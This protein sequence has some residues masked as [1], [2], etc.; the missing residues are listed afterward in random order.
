MYA[1]LLLFQAYRYRISE[2][3]SN[4]NLYFLDFK[5]IVLNPRHIFFL[6]LTRFDILSNPFYNK[7]AN[8]EKR[9]LRISHVNPI[10]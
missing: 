10:K 6:L 7:F 5:T 4:F 1:A 3:H 2:F 8:C 9:A